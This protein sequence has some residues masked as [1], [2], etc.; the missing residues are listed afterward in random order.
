MVGKMEPCGVGLPFEPRIRSHGFE[1]D[2]AIFKGAPGMM[3]CRR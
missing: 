1:F 2:A 3:G